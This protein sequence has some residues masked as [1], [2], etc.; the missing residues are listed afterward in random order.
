MM[1]VRLLGPWAAKPLGL[2]TMN[3]LLYVLASHRDRDRPYTVVM[4][5]CIIRYQ[6]C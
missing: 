2:S 3:E 4:V 1:C 6:S 5:W